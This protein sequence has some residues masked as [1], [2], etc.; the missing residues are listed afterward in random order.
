MVNTATG[1]SPPWAPT[2][3][4]TCSPIRFNC[5]VQT[6]GSDD[7]NYCSTQVNQENNNMQDVV[8]MNEVDKDQTILQF[9]SPT[10]TGSTNNTPLLS[11]LLSMVPIPL[12]SI[13][14]NINTSESRQWPIGPPARYNFKYRQRRTKTSYQNRRRHQ[15]YCRECLSTSQITA[16]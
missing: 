6:S 3:E 2:R 10:S 7:L 8:V 9:P 1:S 15:C 12:M 13:V 5:S 4:M 14:K 16:A 11:S